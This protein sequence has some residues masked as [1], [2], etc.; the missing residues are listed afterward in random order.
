MTLDAK[1]DI[2]TYLVLNLVN[3]KFWDDP[4]RENEILI[5][6][7]SNLINGKVELVPLF[8]IDSNL[9]NGKVELVP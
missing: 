8:N 6:M 1:H 9:I 3:K 2:C 5:Y 7:D 4:C